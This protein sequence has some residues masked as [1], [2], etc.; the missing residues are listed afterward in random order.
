[1]TEKLL[2]GTLSLNTN[3]QDL[4]KGLLQADFAI[5]SKENRLK[6]NIT[7]YGDFFYYLLR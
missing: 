2:T 3:K 1:M 6:I 7:P 4:V 5:K